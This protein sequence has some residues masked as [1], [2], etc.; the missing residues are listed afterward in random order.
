MR[1]CSILSHHK[2]VSSLPPWYHL[3]SFCTTKAARLVTESEPVHLQGGDIPAKP[4]V[5]EFLQVALLDAAGLVFEQKDEQEPLYCREGTLLLWTTL[6]GWCAG[7][8]RESGRSIVGHVR[9]PPGTGKSTTTF[10]WLQAHVNETGNSAT[11][12]HV[13]SGNL[14]YGVVFKKENGV[15]LYTTQG[16]GVVSALY[17]RITACKSTVLVLDGAKGTALFKNSLIPSVRVWAADKPGER[18]AV[19][20]SSGAVPEIRIEDAVNLQTRYEVFQNWSWT[21]GEYIRAF[22]RATQNPNFGRLVLKKRR[23]EAA[24]GDDVAVAN[25]ASDAVVVAAEDSAL[26]K[27]VLEDTDGQSEENTLANEVLEDID[28]KYFYAGG[29]ARYFFGFSNEK[30][31]DEIKKAVESLS[32]TNIAEVLSTGNNHSETRHRLVSFFQLNKN[33]DTCKSIV[34]QYAVQQLVEHA[35]EQAF[36][37]LYGLGSANPSFDGWVFE[38]DFFFQYKSVNE[39][40]RSLTL[41]KVLE[42]GSNV[43]IPAH[44]PVRDFDHDAMTAK[45]RP[46]NSRS[47]A[48]PLP[49]LKE[50]VKGCLQKMKNKMCKP[51]KWNQGGYDGFY[52]SINPGGTYM[53]QFFQV[54]RGASHKLNLRYFVEVVQLFLDAGLDVSGVQIYFVVPE[55]QTTQV[56]DFTPYGTLFHEKFGWENGQEKRQICVVTLKK[57]TP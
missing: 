13:D 5:G 47:F 27:E 57:K 18:T 44:S 32:K 22:K 10:A 8:T 26:V 29:C 45:G 46:L 6:S 4:I 43:E 2:F 11:W 53:I 9:G 41:K 49:A 17:T 37:F 35:G 48:K 50:E 55:G 23:V 52:V 3:R 34:S 20:V 15:V 1:L 28:D 42:D 56:S 38:A 36:I 16:H 33:G 51:T 24:P 25:A 7:S 19:L 39:T 40:G 12:F 14:V 54:T 30:V 31:K 21:R